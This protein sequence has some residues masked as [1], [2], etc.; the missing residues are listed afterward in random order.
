MTTHSTT[1]VHDLRMGQTLYLSRRFSLVHETMT[2]SVLDLRRDMLPIS[3]EDFLSSMRRRLIRLL[4]YSTSGGTCS[5]YPKRDFLLV[6]ETTTYSTTAVLDIRMGQAPYLPKRDF[7]LV[8]ETTT[9][10]TTAVL[11]IQMGQTPYLQKKDFF[12]TRR[13]RIIWPLWY[14]ILGRDKFPISK[15]ELSHP[16]GD[17]SSTATH[18]VSWRYKTS[19]SYNGT[20]HPQDDKQIDYYG[21][22]RNASSQPMTSSIKKQPANRTSNKRK[23]YYTLEC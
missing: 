14:S 20:S 7:L 3:Q 6:H 23:K 15:Q 11:N 22:R 5:P 17:N 9:Y 10:S 21:T 16:R 13:R 12:S 18:S 4:R 2:T 8:H 1:T 19:D